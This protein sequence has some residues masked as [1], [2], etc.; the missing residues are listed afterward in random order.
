M[1]RR[2]ITLIVAI[3]LIWVTQSMSAQR[4]GSSTIRDLVGTWT[5][6][7][8]ERPGT[9]SGPSSVPNPRGLL[10]YDA[11][12]HALEIV[13][14]GGRAPY[15]AGQPTPAE[16]MTTLATYG[17]FWGSYRADAQQ[18]RITYRNE[19][20][21]NPSLMGQEEVRS[22]E[23]RAGRLT[24]TS[25]RAQPSAP[26]GT[27]WVWERVPVL[28]GLSPAHRRLVGFWQHVVEQ[29]VNRAGAALSETRRAPSVIVYTPAGYVGVHFPPLGRK[30]FAGEQ[31]TAEEAQ[32]A[33]RGYVSYFG[34]YTLYP[35]AVYHHQLAALGPGQGNTLRRFFEISGTQISLR[36]PPTQVQGEETRTVVTLKR[37]SGEADMLPVN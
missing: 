37:L 6:V 11:A 19:G 13:T 32:A 9:G 23:Y 30:P 27:R 1:P 12:G 16:T 25:L 18:G 4:P 35:G 7:S 36:F 3:T 5:L 8:V 24:L 14:R 17:G 28:E 10:V 15:A 34:V 26:S 31:P 33:I 21:I 2:S 29:R 20:A 22:Y